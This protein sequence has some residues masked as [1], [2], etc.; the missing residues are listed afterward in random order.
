[1]MDETWGWPSC[2][3]GLL[4]RF[5]HQLVGH[6][7]SQLPP[8]NHPGEAIHEHGQVTERQRHDR[9][10]TGLGDP[11]SIR[12]VHFFEI[13]KQVLVVAQSTSAVGGFRFEGLGLDRFKSCFS[14]S[15]ATRRRPSD[16][17][18]SRNLRL[19]ARNCR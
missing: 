11:Q 9:H 16:C 2:F 7:F 5:D 19:C 4:E 1:M 12:S 13:N 15:F 6:I 8:H 3:D 10:V 17:P 18:S 14:I